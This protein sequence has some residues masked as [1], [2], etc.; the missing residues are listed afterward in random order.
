M[1]ARR[2]RGKGASKLEV[3]TLAHDNGVCEHTRTLTNF[4]HHGLFKKV[5]PLSLHVAGEHPVGVDLRVSHH[6]ETSQNVVHTLGI[7]DVWRTVGRRGGAAEG[8]ERRKRRGEGEERD[9]K[10]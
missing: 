6:E 9:M 10:R 5:N 4:L 1:K 3:K 7:P 2:S 8:R